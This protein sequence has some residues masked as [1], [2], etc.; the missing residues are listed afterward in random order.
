[1]VKRPTGSD[2]EP[3]SPNCGASAGGR[4]RHLNLKKMSANN[5]LQKTR[6]VSVLILCHLSVSPTLKRSG[7]M[8]HLTGLFERQ[9]SYYLRIV[10]PLN[11]P[12]KNRYKSGK[13]VQS[14]G[15][16]TYREALRLGEKKRA[17]VL[18]G[19][20]LVAE[21]SLDHSDELSRQLKV[22]SDENTISSVYLRDVFD[23]WIKAKQRSSDTL[24]S[25][26]RALKLYENHT[27]NPSL[28]QLTRAQGD[29][30]RAGLGRIHT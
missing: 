7:Y 19:Y 1:M 21:L 5:E 29:K 26:S 4:A 13:I 14:L 6:H 15:R 11:H 28:N 18:W 22:H 12:L 23:K 2:G 25:C 20:K 17:E 30:F 16:C 9:G 8:A 27:G 10:L 24:A 3:S